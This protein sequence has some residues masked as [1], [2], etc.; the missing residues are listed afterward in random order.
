MVVMERQRITVAALRLWIGASI[1][2]SKQRLPRT[3]GGWG[4]GYLAAYDVARTRQKREETGKDTRV[5]HR[6][7]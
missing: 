7:L 5:G 6:A 3:G 4:G 2:D 1:G